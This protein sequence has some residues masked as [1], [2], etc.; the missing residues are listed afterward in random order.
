M[1]IEELELKSNK[2][3]AETKKCQYAKPENI[4]KAK[5]MKK[6]RARGIA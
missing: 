3:C 4:Q 6:M 1:C 2:L 5:R